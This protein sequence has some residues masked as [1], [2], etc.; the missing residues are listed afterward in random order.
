MPYKNRRKYKNNKYFFKEDLKNIKKKD[1]KI[2]LENEVFQREAFKRHINEVAQKTNID[3]EIVKDVIKSY[4]TNIS[5]VMN[6]ILKIKT[7][8]NIYGFFYFDIEK[9]KRV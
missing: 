4:I 6:T 7:R 8:I 2:Y 9:G 5:I 1:L 3:E